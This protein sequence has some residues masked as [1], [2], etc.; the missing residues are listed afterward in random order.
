MHS[1]WR[2]S[3]QPGGPALIA[4]CSIK[5]FENHLFPGASKKLI[6]R[7]ALVRVRQSIQRICIGNRLVNQKIVCIQD[8]SATEQQRSLNDIFQVTHV[9]WPVM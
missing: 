5:R 8:I 9:A 2:D 1:L 3:K 7:E 6:Q 4:A